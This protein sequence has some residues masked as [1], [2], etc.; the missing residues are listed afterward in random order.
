METVSLKLPDALE[1]E[2]LLRLPATWEDCIAVVEDTPYTIQFLS[3]EIIG[4]QANV[5][6]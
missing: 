2:E 4:S 1:E 3:G 5:D 6:H